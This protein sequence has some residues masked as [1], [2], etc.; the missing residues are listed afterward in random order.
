MPNAARRSSCALRLRGMKT[1]TR[2]RIKLDSLYHMG[3]DDAAA[4]KEFIREK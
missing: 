1:L 3:Y 2:D 4:I